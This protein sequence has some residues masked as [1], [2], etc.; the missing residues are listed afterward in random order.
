M[1][2]G[3]RGY[4]ISYYML[5]KVLIKRFHFDIT[6]IGIEYWTESILLSRK[7]GNFVKMVNLYKAIGEKNNT[8]AMAVER[9]MRYA[10]NTAKEKI[11]EVFEIDVKLTNASIYKLMLEYFV[12]GDISNEYKL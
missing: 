3:D 6:S 5:R 11:K 9:A 8:S 1:I 12:K 4:G 7:N 2:I 10:S